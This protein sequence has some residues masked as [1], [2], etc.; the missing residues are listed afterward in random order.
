MASRAC[1]RLQRLFTQLSGNISKMET[2]RV[3]P[4]QRWWYLIASLKQFWTCL[5][6]GE[7]LFPLDIELQ[8]SACAISVY[9]LPCHCL[10]R[11]LIICYQAT[12]TISQ[13]INASFRIFDLISLSATLQMFQLLNCSI[14]DCRLT[15]R[16][17]QVRSPPGAFLCG[18]CMFSPCMRGF[19]PG[20]PASSHC[21]K[22]CML[23]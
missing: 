17:F 21:P 6:E 22:T 12:S 2:S 18:V 1:T 10:W 16:V 13:H 4:N 20:T 5:Y 9:I 15:A 3:K 19:S 14:K 7:D 8:E 11:H 23:G